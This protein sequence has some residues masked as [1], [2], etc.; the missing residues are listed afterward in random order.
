MF[1]PRDNKMEALIN[2]NMHYMYNIPDLLSDGASMWLAAIV[3][4]DQE[5]DAERV[6]YIK[7]QPHKRLK[8]MQKCLKRSQDIKKYRLTRQMPA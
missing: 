3:A 6:I 2:S 7:N 5:V 4:L 1:V 8:I